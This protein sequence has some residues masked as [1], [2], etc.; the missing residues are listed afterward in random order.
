MS[1][2][3][4]FVDKDMS[5]H[6]C[7]LKKIIYGLRQAPRAWYMELC[8]FVLTLGFVQSLANT[9]LFIYHLGSALAYLLV[10]VDDSVVISS[11]DSLVTLIWWALADRFSIKDLV[12]LNYFLGIEV[13]RTSKGF[14]MIQR[15]YIVYLLTKMNMLDAKPVLTPLASS[16]KITLHSGDAM[17]DLTQF[18]TIVGSLQYLPFTLLDIA[19]VFNQLSQ[20]MHRSTTDHCQAAKRALWYLA[21]TISHGIYFKAIT[22]WLFM[23]ILMLIGLAKPM[24]LSPKMPTISM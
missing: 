15:K 17:D 5:N 8:N 24:T 12:E 2:P 10:Y 23:L 6:V 1:Q 19:Y 11:S 16:P 13:T 14:H 20:F 9:S 7:W 21:G 3:P 22:L 18:R 4:A